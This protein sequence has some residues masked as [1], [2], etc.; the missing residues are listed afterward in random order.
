MRAPRRGYARHDKTGRAGAERVRRACIWHPI[1]DG[2]RYCLRG[3]V[4]RTTGRL[5]AAWEGAPGVSELRPLTEAEVT[6]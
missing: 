2:A 6:L 5:V 3:L 1:V 4:E